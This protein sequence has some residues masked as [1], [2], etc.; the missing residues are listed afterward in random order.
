MKFKKLAAMITMALALV[1]MLGVSSTQTAQ[2]G[3]GDPYYYFS[4]Q[5]SNLQLTKTSYQ[6]GSEQTIEFSFDAKETYS[7][8]SFND[9]GDTS[10]DVVIT[11][12]EGKIV[13]PKD[14]YIN[15][16]RSYAFEYEDYMEEAY[17]FASDFKAGTNKC[18]IRCHFEDRGK[19]TFT[20]YAN[21]VYGDAL[22]KTTF[23]VSKAE[24]STA[25]YKDTIKILKPTITVGSTEKIS[26]EYTVADS[27]YDY[28]IYMVEPED[29]SGNDAWITSYEDDMRRFNILE[30]F[31]S[32]AGEFDVTAGKVNKLTFSSRKYD[33]E[34]MYAIV[35]Y[36]VTKGKKGAVENF[37]CA[38]ASKQLD[39]DIDTSKVDKNGNLPFMCKSNKTHLD[40][41]S[42]D[43]ITLDVQFPFKYEE[44]LADF[45]R[46]YEYGTYGTDDNANIK[47]KVLYTPAGSSYTRTLMPEKTIK[48]VTSKHSVSFKAA[49]ILE[50]ILDTKEGDQAY[51][52][53]VT[54]EFIYD[55]MSSMYATFFDEKFNFSVAKKSKLVSAG[56]KSKNVARAYGENAIFVAESTLGGTV[57]ADI[58]KGS[59]KIATAT[60]LSS[61]GSSSLDNA[62]GLAC[63]NLQ[64]TNGGY[65]ATGNYK[66]KVYTSITLKVINDG[67]TTTKK[68]DSNK[69]TIKFKVVK[70]K[71]SLTL[72]AAAEGTTGGNFAVYEN[73]VISVKPTVSIGSKLNIVLKN[74]KGTTLKTYDTVQCAGTGN[75][76]FDIAALDPSYGLGTYK[77]SVTATTLDGK[78][79]SASTSFSIKKSPKVQLSSVVLTTKDGVGSVAFNTSE[80]SAVT[81]VVKDSAGSVV[82]TVIDKSYSKGKIS[83]SFAYGSLAVGSYNVVFTAKNSGGTSTVTKTFKVEKKPVVVTKPTVSGLAIRWTT[84]NKEDALTSS[85]YYTGKGATIVIEVLWNDAEEI[86]YTYKTTTTAEKGSVSFTWDGYKSNGFRA[87]QGSYTIRAYAVNSAGKTEYLRQ[88]FSIAAG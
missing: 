55:D 37:I 63:Y 21:S 72:K 44:F 36:N 50:A 51:A 19:Y 82:N 79:K 7:S 80:Q 64:N 83:A 11:D 30:D 70:A 32:D 58:Y 45:T 65:I 17:F 33:K 43:T 29:G 6:L 75:Y 74:S 38:A 69:K 24:G 57:C 60:G 53:I 47:M 15:G 34:G 61:L 1:I 41:D 88:N 87:T 27:D 52:G 86:V 4:E 62:V 31:R 13:H 22:Y 42:N 73:P 76:W 68:I 9:W 5:I 14:S 20:V 10:F 59:K 16:E 39:S 77:V 40:L 49:D 84:K 48:G 71:G 67:K 54:V 56:I 25:D 23:T 81:V 2:A 66:A 78:K 8:D 12:A 35:L 85:L 3:Y 26:I 18:S 46:Q 28:K